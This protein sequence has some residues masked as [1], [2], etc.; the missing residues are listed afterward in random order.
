MSGWVITWGVWRAVWV[1]LWLGA[2]LVMNFVLHLY[3]K[4]HQVLSVNDIGDVDNIEDSPRNY[5][6]SI[7]CRWVYLIRL[8]CNMVPR[9]HFNVVTGLT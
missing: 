1:G 5:N 2:D 6:C 7:S 9:N 4:V 3:Y 8:G